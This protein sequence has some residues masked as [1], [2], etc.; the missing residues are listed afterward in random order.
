MMKLFWNNKNPEP[1]IPEEKIKQIIDILFPQ[2]HLHEQI[3]ESGISYKYHIDYSVDS[4]L[5]AALMDLQEGKND[6]I[7]HSTITKAITRLN[8][9]RRILEAYASID[10]E[11]KYIIVDDGEDAY[12]E[13]RE[14]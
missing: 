2:L 12:V 5:D 14:D 6:P 1:T 7:V 3:D 4:N 11:A 8:K 10:P 9:A 13:A